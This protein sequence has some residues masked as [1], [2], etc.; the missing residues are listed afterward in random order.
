MPTFI[1]ISLG[2]SSIIKIIINLNGLFNN[3]LHV[4]SNIIVSQ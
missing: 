4:Q 3:L 1:Q 2:M